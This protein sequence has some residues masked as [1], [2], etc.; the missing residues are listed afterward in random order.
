MTMG[1]GHRRATVSMI[2]SVSNMSQS[3]LCGHLLCVLF[4]HELP[5]FDHKLTHTFIRMCTSSIDLKICY[6]GKGRLTFI[7]TKRT[8]R[9]TETEIPTFHLRLS[10]AMRW[11]SPCQDCHS[12]CSG[13]PDSDSSLSRASIFES[14]NQSINLSKSLCLD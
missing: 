4:C 10:S 8:D 3:L 1:I 2:T 9:Q 12:C 6:N 14:I 11:L 5:H 7:V 13:T